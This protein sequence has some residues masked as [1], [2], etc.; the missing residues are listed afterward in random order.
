M[1]YTIEYAEQRAARIAARYKKLVPPEKATSLPSQLPMFYLVSGFEHPS[2]PIVKNDGIFLFEWGLIPSWIKDSSSAIEIQNRTLNAVG[3]TVFEKPSY[4]K[5]ILEQRCL[6]PVHGFYEWRSFQKKKYPYLIQV[7][8]NAIFSLG[9]IYE[10]WVNRATGE[11]KNTFSILTTPANPM[12]EKIHNLKKRMPLILREE[13]EKQWVDP[14]LTHDQ[15]VAL[16]KPYDD[17]DMTAHTVSQFANSVHHLRNVPEI[18][19][20]VYYPELTEID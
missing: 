9:A 13:D 2:L 8:S 14:S 20:A 3:E 5:S 15:I 4:K 11:T 19:A 16:I 17:H 7:R 12:M 6:L 10:T 1:C 18:T